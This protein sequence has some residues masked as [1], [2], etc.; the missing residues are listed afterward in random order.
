MIKQEEAEYFFKA[1]MLEKVNLGKLTDEMLM[2]FKD[3]LFVQE[4]E[5]LQA[6]L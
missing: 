4:I 2:N 5:D 1:R 3:L 6:L